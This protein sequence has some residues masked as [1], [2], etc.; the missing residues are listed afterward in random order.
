MGAEEYKSVR[1]GGNS[2]LF[3]PKWGQLIN[4]DCL[5]NGRITTGITKKIT[6]IGLPQDSRI[7][8]AETTDA[9]T[10]LGV[11]SL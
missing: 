2:K 9:S 4:P 5:S 10:L 11:S 1:N 6:V 7:P 8:T 3:G